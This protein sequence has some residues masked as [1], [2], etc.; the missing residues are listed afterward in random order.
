MNYVMKVSAGIALLI[1]LSGCPPWCPVA[2]FRASIQF[3]QAA[4][5]VQFTDVSRPGCAP[6]T[7]WQWD[8]GDGGTAT[9]QNP[10]H[11]YTTPGTYTVQLTVTS[12]KG[13]SRRTYEDL[14]VVGENAVV[15]WNDTALEAVADAQLMP[16]QAARI[17]AM[18]HAA[19]YDAIN[20]VEQGGDPYC[21]DID[22][23][24][25][26]SKEA[27]AAQAAH[28]VLSDVFPGKAIDFGTRLTQSLDAIPETEDKPAG[29]I[30]GQEAADAILALRAD[31]GSQVM[32]MDPYTGGTE[33]GEWRPTPPMNTPGMFY[34]WR[35]VTPFALT[36]ADQFRPPSPPALDS[37]RYAD[38]LNEVKLLGVKNNS[39]RT[40][41]QSMVANFWVGMAGTIGEA[42]RMNLVAQQAAEAN[43]NTLYEN[44]ALF[45]LVNFALADAAIAGLDCKYTYSFWRPISAIREADEDGNDGTTLDSEWESFLVT[46]AHPEYISTH[47]ALTKAAAVVL[48]NFFGTDD[49]EL[50]LP[51]FMDPNVTRTYASFSE[52]A[53]EA[54][55]SRLY[56]GIHFRFSY[57]AGSTLGQQI[58]EYVYDNLLLPVQ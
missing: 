37:D 19:M 5:P 15:S 3:G 8:F 12:E 32:Q 20:A 21:A 36:A 50:T 7:N 55:L 31:D 30:I 6:I 57:E 47:S 9:V 41:E 52:V 33:P 22:A 17:L 39:S 44:A 26:A 16:P 2:D 43:A 34:P 54:G 58:G 23:P 13:T 38:D 51:A 56:G 49:A 18:M 11:T 46:P 28:D 45:A 35:L 48:M 27:A 42:G 25:G 40:M 14:I 4:L 1:T 24:E 53:E 29:I 10:L